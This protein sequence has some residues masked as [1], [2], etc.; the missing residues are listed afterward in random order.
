MAEILL[1]T[2]PEATHVVDRLVGGWYDADLTERGVEQAG[3]IAAA[4]GPADAVFSSTLTRCR[5]TAEAVAANAGIET[6]LD[7]D[8]REQSYGVAGGRPPGTFPF[9][10]HTAADDALRHHDGVAGSETRL[11]VATRVY[12]ATA[13][14][15]AAGHERTVVVS[16]GGASTYVVLAWLGVPVEAVGSMR[17][18][19]SPGSITRLRAKDNGDRHVESLAEVGH[20]R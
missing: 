6:T 20:L 11:D 15:E 12:R 7:P 8:L 16:H 17:L 3:L 18:G 10:P 5:R 2:H 13:R 1:V 19:F 4:I 14:V 9:T